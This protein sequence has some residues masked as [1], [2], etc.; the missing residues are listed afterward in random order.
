MRAR[1]I[2]LALWTVSAAM[3]AEAQSPDWFDAF[4]GRAFLQGDASFVVREKAA[5]PDSPPLFRAR[6]VVLRYAGFTESER[7][8]WPYRNLLLTTMPSGARYVLESSMGFLDENRLDEERPWQRVASERAAFE[9]WT[10][11]TAGEASAAA[12]LDAG[13]CEGM[14]QRVRAQGGTLTFLLDDLGTQTVRTALGE[15]TAGTF[16]ENERKD[17]VLLLRT[18][19]DSNQSLSTELPA[20]HLRDPLLAVNV[21]FRDQ[22][23]PPESRTLAFAPDPSP[24]GDLASWRGLAHLPLDLP[25]FPAI[26]TESPVR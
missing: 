11:G 15:I 23:A 6:W 17:L 14:R 22:A 16:D 26:V 20:F 3:R 5:P 13:P 9:V 4:R 25:P 8:W 7:R 24:T 1:G 21:A 10:S 18:S 12:T 19:V 2:L